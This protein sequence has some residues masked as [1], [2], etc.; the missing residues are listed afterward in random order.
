MTNNDDFDID[1]INAQLIA[2]FFFPL[3]KKGRS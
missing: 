3:N 1:L 2:S